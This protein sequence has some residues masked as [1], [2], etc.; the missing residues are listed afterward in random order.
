[1]GND[2]LD[3]GFDLEK[4]KKMEVSEG[5]PITKSMSDSVY[6]KFAYKWL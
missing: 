3:H 2:S 4:Y 5:K 1:M 6:H